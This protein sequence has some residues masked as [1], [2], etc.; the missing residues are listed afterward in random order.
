MSL[1]LKYRPDDLNLVKG[2]KDI[3]DTLKGMLSNLETCPHSF[4]LHG[5]TGCGK[6]TIARIIAKRLGCEGEDSREIDSAD[7]R[8]IDTIRDL[9]K[10]S[11]YMA[12]SSENRIWIIDECHKLTNDAQNALLKI[13]EEPPSHVYFVL[14]TTEPNKLLETIKGRCI[15]LQVK[16]LNDS[17]MK[18]MFRK[19]LMAEGITLEDEIQ[20]QIIQ[21]SLGLPRNAINILEQ[22]IN[23]PAEQRMEVA[24]QTAAQQGEVINLCRALMDNSNWK[25][26]KTILDSIRDQEPENIRRMVLGYCQSTL[27]RNENDRAAAIME[28]FW[29]PTYNIGFPGVVYAC[30]SVVKG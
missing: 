4:L 6:T 12:T 10:K 13:L 14:C 18:G 23:A 19:I 20:D 29:E 1:A 28:A 27:L 21:D 25:K 11:Q 7:F 2:N 17:Q 24:R 8:G 5:Q 22:V 9:R 15:Q 3:V 30:Y 26:V 16:P